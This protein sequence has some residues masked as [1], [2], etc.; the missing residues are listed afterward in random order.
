MEWN[1]FEL[2]TG[3]EVVVA[4]SGQHLLNLPVKVEESKVQKMIHELILVFHITLID[5]LG[6]RLAAGQ[7]AFT[8]VF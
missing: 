3:E 8:K 1:N 5:F 7:Q 4:L 6:C 2:V